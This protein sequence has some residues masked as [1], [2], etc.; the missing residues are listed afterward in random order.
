MLAKQPMSE[1]QLLTGELE[2]SNQ[3]H[4]IAKIAGI[5]LCEAYR[6]QHDSDFIQ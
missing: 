6:R 1:D 5:K 3:S 2:P 4:P